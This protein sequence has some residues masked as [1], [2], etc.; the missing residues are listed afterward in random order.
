MNEKT[1]WIAEPLDVLCRQCHGA[2]CSSCNYTGH[3]RAEPVACETC[4][5][6][7]YV[8]AGVLDVCDTCHPEIMEL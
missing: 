7:L 8:V 4:G 6:L 1:G 2:R 3:A 5:G